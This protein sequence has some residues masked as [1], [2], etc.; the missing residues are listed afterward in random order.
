M[1]R[2]L[3]RRSA[4]GAGAVEAGAVGACVIGAGRRREGEQAGQDGA[5]A[6]RC[7]AV[8]ALVAVEEVDELLEERAE[9]GQREP[10]RAARVGEGVGP[11]P[12]VLPLPLEPLEEFEVGG[13]R[14]VVQLVHDEPG[15]GV[16]AAPGREAAVTRDGSPPALTPTHAPALG[17]ALLGESV[18]GQLTQVVAGGAGVHPEVAGQHRGGRGAVEG[19]VLEDLLAAGLSQ[20]LQSAEIAQLLA[21]GGSGGAGFRCHAYTLACAHIPVHCG[22]QAS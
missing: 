5:C 10:D 7:L 9:F 11:L 22:D 19:E 6:V 3:V 13:V 17:R 8:G 18:A 20:R 1:L 14:E 21:A 2:S 15:F 16:L 12:Q 4:V